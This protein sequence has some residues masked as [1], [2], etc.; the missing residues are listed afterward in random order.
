MSFIEAKSGPGPLN[1]RKEVTKT[2]ETSIKTVSVS[3]G[4]EQSC[5]MPP[6]GGFIYS[7]FFGK[8]FFVH[9]FVKFRF[10]SNSKVREL[11]VRAS[12]WRLDSYIYPGI[13]WKPFWLRSPLMLI[14]TSSLFRR[15]RL[16]GSIKKR[17][18]E[19]HVSF[20][21]CQ[22]SCIR[23]VRQTLRL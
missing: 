12:G 7:L 9:D 5:N 10:I 20:E 4:K 15:R 2:F 21:H 6:G 14:R 19:G 13:H 11:S 22:L 1:R 18:F 3:R 8:K 16:T 23:F 17:P